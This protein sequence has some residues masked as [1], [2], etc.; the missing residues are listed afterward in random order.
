MPE[1]EKPREHHI[2]EED[3]E[4]IHQLRAARRALS[5]L[6]ALIVLLGA[7]YLAISS[8]HHEKPKRHGTAPASQRTCP[9]N[10]RL[11]R[12]KDMAIIRVESW[13]S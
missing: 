10:S 1:P 5:M 2:S 12:Q 8:L 9:L 7:I 3:Q 11:H 4:T 13:T 6:A